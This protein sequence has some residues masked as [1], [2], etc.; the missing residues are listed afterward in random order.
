MI[1]SRPKFKPRRPPLPLSDDRLDKLIAAMSWYVGRHKD[2][3]EY[4]GSPSYY[5]AVSEWF[6]RLSL[7]DQERAHTVQYVYSTPRYG[8]EAAAITYAALLPS[9]PPPNEL[10]RKA[11][12]HG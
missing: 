4:S 9:V 7:D 2:R 3:P 1:R 12:G 10:V 6:D 11:W 8:G 5:A